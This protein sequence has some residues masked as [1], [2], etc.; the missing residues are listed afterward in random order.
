[1]QS[2]PFHWPIYVVH[3]LYRFRCSPV[4][5]SKWD[6]VRE[7]SHRRGRDIMRWRGTSLVG[8]TVRWQPILAVLDHSFIHWFV[9]LC[10]AL[11]YVFQWISLASESAEI[12]LRAGT[13]NAINVLGCPCRLAWIKQRMRVLNAA[14]ECLVGSV[15]PAEVVRF[16]PGLRQPEEGGQPGQSGHASR[17]C[18]CSS[19]HRQR[20]AEYT[21]AV[22]RGAGQ[23]SNA[24]S[25]SCSI[26][27]PSHPLGCFRCF[28]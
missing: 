17:W 22:D 2:C 20:M 14:I 9:H 26:R 15:V 27:V 24:V 25:F 21:A 6:N 28:V 18:H 3:F 5:P 4:H 19:T 10:K 16:P 23:Q 7:P 8:R 11:I 12:V 13:I 1:M